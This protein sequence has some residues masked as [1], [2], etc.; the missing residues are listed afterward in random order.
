MTTTTSEIEIVTSNQKKDL[1]L[2]QLEGKF[3]GVEV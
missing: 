3:E 2:S 1:W